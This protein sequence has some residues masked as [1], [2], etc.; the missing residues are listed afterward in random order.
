MSG[1]KHCSSSSPLLIGAI[2]LFNFAFADGNA[3]D[4]TDDDVKIMKVF[5]GWI[6]PGAVA[7]NVRNFVLAIIGILALI[8]CLC[9]LVSLL[10]CLR[11][12]RQQKGRS[13]K[14]REVVKEERHRLGI[15]TCIG[16]GFKDG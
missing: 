10:L 4:N 11:W 7:G 14:Q 9:F 1:F 8:A 3:V 15:G 6:S 2:L 5:F 12:Q 16:R 13:Q